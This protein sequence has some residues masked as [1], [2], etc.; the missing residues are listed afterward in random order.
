[1]DD[2]TNLET[3]AQLNRMK[4]LCHYLMDLETHPCIAD[5]QRDKLFDELNE[6]K[7]KI[8]KLTLAA[9]KKYEA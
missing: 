4:A 6:L 2:T 3:R 8:D 5:D 9:S 1:M 7:E